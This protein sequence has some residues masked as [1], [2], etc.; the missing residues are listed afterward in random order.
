M[1]K[2][3]FGDTRSLRRGAGV[4]LVYSDAEDDVVL[5]VVEEIDVR[6]VLDVLGDDYYVLNDVGLGR[7]RIDHVVV[8]P[9]GLCT[10]NLREDVGTVTDFRGDL[11]LDGKPFDR[12]LVGRAES[13]AAAVRR[14]LQSVYDRTFRVAPLL[15]FTRASLRVYHPI[16]GVAVLPL[17]WLPSALREGPATISPFD[18]AAVSYALAERVRR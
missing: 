13:D 16:E 14:Y 17:K 9:T 2:V 1:P 6:S 15:I 12:D 5:G 18:R 3:V 4:E 7:T 11:L 10:L 8:G